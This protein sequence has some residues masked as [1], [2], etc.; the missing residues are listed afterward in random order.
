MAI[1]PGATAASWQPD[2]NRAVPDDG[3]GVAQNSNSSTSALTAS[4]I[5]RSPTAAPFSVG[6]PELG[7]AAFLP[8]SLPSRSFAGELPDFD[9]EFDPLVSPLASAA[10]RRPR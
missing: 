9:N 3:G 8:G 1:S 4:S 2:P 6:D 10:Q 7:A 5:S